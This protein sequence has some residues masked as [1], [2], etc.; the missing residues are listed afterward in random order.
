MNSDII[1]ETERLILKNWEL[2]D[3][4][5]FAAIAR[6]PQ[7]M[8]YIAEGLPWSDSRI[9]WFMGLQR[10]HQHG[11]GYCCW[12]LV[13]K[14][15]NHLIGLCGLAPVFSLGETEIGWWLKPSHWHQGFAQEAALFVADAAFKQHGV[16]RLIA[17]VYDGNHASIRLIDKLGMSLVRTLK[18]TD[19]GSIL[20]YQM[21]RE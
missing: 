5:A 10:A 8:R 13:E 4:E 20:L 19:V 6:D 7:V 14:D 12:K 21:E 18:Q 3:F 15:S 11:L 2:D 16:D 9:G 17:R 1:H